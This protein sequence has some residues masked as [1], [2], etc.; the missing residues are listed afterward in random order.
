MGL[1]I[2][3]LRLTY[4]I[5]VLIKRIACIHSIP[6]ADWWADA[7]L[8]KWLTIR[9][10]FSLRKRQLRPGCVVA[11]SVIVG[12]DGFKWRCV[13][14]DTVQ[15][16]W[17]TI[18]KEISWNGWNKLDNKHKHKMFAFVK[19]LYFCSS[20]CGRGLR[21]EIE[22]QQWWVMTAT[23]A[24]NSNRVCKKSALVTTCPKITLRIWEILSN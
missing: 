24:F 18:G 7:K 10:S 13:E 6:V 8:R 11:T 19:L 12:F 16:I 17:K 15:K 20:N 2:R 21:C 23:T 5:Y 14:M 1:K 3:T 9:T 22:P 4:I